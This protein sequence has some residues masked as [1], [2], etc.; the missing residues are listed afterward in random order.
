MTL[1]EKVGK[2]NWKDV[3][4]EKRRCKKKPEMYLLFLYSVLIY[5]QF[6]NVRMGPVCWLGDDIEKTRSDMDWHHVK[7]VAV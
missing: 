7:M 2:G 1:K 3:L 6:Y 4:V 5:W